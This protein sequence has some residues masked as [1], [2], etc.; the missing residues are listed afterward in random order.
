PSPVCFL[1][2][3]DGALRYRAHQN[4]AAANLASGSLRRAAKLALILRDALSHLPFSGSSMNASLTRCFTPTA[5][6][7]RWRLAPRLLRA[8]AGPIGGFAVLLLFW[9]SAALA[10]MEVPA[11]SATLLAAWN[12]FANPFHDY[13]GHDI[14]IGWNIVASVQRLWGAYLIA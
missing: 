1:A 4:G 11:P 8:L 6:D 12:L 5:L 13:G 3:H 14:G 9:Q 2:H 7:P 10:I